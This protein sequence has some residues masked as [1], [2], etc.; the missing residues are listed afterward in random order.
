MATPIG[1][2]AAGYGFFLFS[3]KPS[4]SLRG[5]LPFWSVFFALAPDLD[6]LP[7]LLVGKPA[8]YH[9]GLSHSIGI[10]TLTGLFGAYLFS[11]LTRDERSFIAVFLLFASTYCSHLFL[12]L[13]SLDGRPPYGIPLLWPFSQEYFII[14]LLPGVHHAPTTDASIIEWLV[15]ILSWHNLLVIGT[16]VAIVG[17]FLLLTYA[18]RCRRPRTNSECELPRSDPSDGGQ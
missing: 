5:F 3:S 8:L 9:H 12:D 14:P 1:H 6:F 4:E 7:G 17:P 2:A 18:I 11:R 16:E 15:G 10:A 13:I